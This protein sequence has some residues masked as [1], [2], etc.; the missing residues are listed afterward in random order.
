MQIKPISVKASTIE[1]FLIK[2]CLA[3]PYYFNK[4]EETKILSFITDMPNKFNIKQ[5]FF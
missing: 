2:H 4:I 1:F 3:I 5:M